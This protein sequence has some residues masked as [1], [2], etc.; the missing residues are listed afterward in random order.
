MEKLNIAAL[1][2]FF[3]DEVAQEPGC[4][5]LHRC[6]ACGVCT[7]TCPVSAVTP[8]FSPSRILRQILYG[9]RRELLSSSA[10]WHCL[11]CAQCSFQCPQDVRFLDIIRGLRNLAIREGFV[12][13][14]LAARTRQAE[15]ILLQ[16]RRHLLA[17]ILANPH[18]TTP[19]EK[20]LLEIVQKLPADRQPQA[21]DE[22]SHDP[23]PALE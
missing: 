4:Q 1:D 6:F 12:P 10:L 14:A 13:A 3:K 17:K 8:E 2:P 18:D 5:H 19:P 9:W 20:L 23:P 11:G 22:L 7:A 16:W 21:E 15:M